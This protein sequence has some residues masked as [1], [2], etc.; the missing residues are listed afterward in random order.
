MRWKEWSRGEGE[1]EYDGLVGS[2]GMRRF[3]NI[4]ER[5]RDE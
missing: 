2:A 3:E 1:T 5:E 4:G